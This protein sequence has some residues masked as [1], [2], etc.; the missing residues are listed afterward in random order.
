MISDKLRGQAD[1][2]AGFALH[3]KPLS[4]QA[5]GILAQV[6]LGYADQAQIMENTWF[7][8]EA[9]A[10]LAEYLDTKRDAA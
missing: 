10:E 4:P 1:R 8:P 5:C 2:L 9:L 3:N 7:A 6:L